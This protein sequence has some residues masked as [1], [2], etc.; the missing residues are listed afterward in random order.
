MNQR[1]QRLIALAC[2]TN[3]ENVILP[4]VE[5]QIP[6][7]N[8]SA[9]G[10]FV[11]KRRERIENWITQVEQQ[12]PISLTVLQN[13]DPNPLLDVPHNFSSN[14]EDEAVTA[15]NDCTVDVK[16]PRRS[17]RKIKKSETVAEDDMLSC[18][19]V[20][21]DFSN[22]TNEYLP[23]HG[24]DSTSHTTG[25]ETLDEPDS[26]NPN[27]QLEDE[28]NKCN[29]GQNDVESIKAENPRTRKRK[30]QPD[31]WE[32]NKRKLLRNSG[33]SYK[34][35]SGKVI[36]AKKM[37]VACNEEKCRLKCSKYVTEDQRK[38]L[39]NE[40]WKLASFQRQRDVI[41]GC[42][43]YNEP[44][45][46][47]T[48]KETPRKAN[49]RFFLQVEGK[50]IQVCKKFLVSTFGISERLLRT[51]IQARYTSKIMAP[52]DKRGKHK[53]HKKVD[54]EVVQSVRDHINSIPRIES[55][56]CREDTE[57]EFIDGVL[58]MAELHRLY[59]KKRAAEKMIPAKYDKYVE[60]FNTEFNIGLF[61]PKKD[62][63]DLCERYKNAEGPEKEAVQKEYDEHQEEKCLIRA[64]KTEDKKEASQNENVNLAVYDL[65][66]VMPVPMGMSS[67]FFYKSKLNCFNF[68]V[69]II[70]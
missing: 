1:T 48:E 24:E 42:I 31:N 54:E 40:Y 8:Y 21:S 5:K 59:C 22:D 50:T 52:E 55:H 17:H 25:S 4:V 70:N 62:Q 16:Y 6:V 39:F 41:L 30:R 32:K 65:E 56:Y 61:V 47:R 57:R 28:E 38:V 23:D 18:S 15:G 36:N 9:T 66:A 43:Q 68:T 67:A 44:R 63:C 58:T 14:P 35:K 11:E 49:A 7:K 46:R 20:L 12:R 69:S 26:N 29:N 34:L 27:T 64:E 33:K 2:S 3:I 60:I 10:N 19:E 53:N 13:L 37:G 51:V 45:Y